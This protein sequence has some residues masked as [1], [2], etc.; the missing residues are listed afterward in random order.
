MKKL[1]IVHFNILLILFSL[2]NSVLTQVWEKFE[3]AF[4][5]NDA[6]LF[7]S[8]HAQNILRIPAD[9]KTLISGKEYFDNQIQSFKWVTENGY[10]TGMELRF[11][12]RINYENHASERGIFRFV[13][14]EPDSTQRIYF[15]KFHVILERESD[16][17]KISMDYDSSEN[18]TIDEKSFIDAFDKWN[19]SPFIGEE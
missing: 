11:I 12:E 9:S 10:K 18:G 15:G 14:T 8:L 5:T 7:N 3:E 4:I 2:E 6:A 13:V 1:L 19:F 17:W 16:I